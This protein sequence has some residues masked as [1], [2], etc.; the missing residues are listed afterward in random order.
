MTFPA[1]LAKVETH[2]GT[3]EGIQRVF[4]TKE[5]DK[6]P[7]DS[8]KKHL[9]HL[10]QGGVWFGNRTATRIAM[11]EGVEDALAAIQALPPGSLENLAVVATVGGGRMH[12]V[13]LPPT[14]RELV[15]LQD[16]NAPGERAWK[17][18]EERY[19][20]SVVA[21]KRIVPNKDVN[22]D[23]VA[24]RA[25]LE[26]L[27][28][29]LVSPGEFEGAPD[30][31][32]RGPGPEAGDLEMRVTV[33][34]EKAAKGGWAAAEFRNLL[35]DLAATENVL[36]RTPAA[37][38]G[39]PVYSTLRDF[40][41][42]AGRAREAMRIAPDSR[43]PWRVSGK[44]GAARSRRSCVRP[45]KPMRHAGSLRIRQGSTSPGRNGQ[46]GR[47]PRS[48]LSGRPPERLGRVL[49]CRRS[50]SGWSTPAPRLPTRGGTPR[51]HPGGG[52]MSSGR[53]GRLT[54]P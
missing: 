9:G 45:T 39:E 47:G 41:A 25:A 24:D 49:S 50:E 11:T 46:A 37:E 36:A 6:A 29:P 38:A 3:F 34:R 28:R 44:S 14:A 35:E 17:D 5:G 54:K 26:H 27:L 19:R 2:D 20:G 18:V 12:S 48:R 33:W 52:T 15:V 16:N 42:D 4:L 23:L 1:L 53:S 21:V 7:I 43:T 13:E 30:H 31:T 8:A 10:Q 51:R 40:A 22:D 32:S